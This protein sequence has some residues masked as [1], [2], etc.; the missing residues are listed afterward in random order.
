MTDVNMP[1]EYK[2]VAF[3]NSIINKSLKFK[4][5]P[6]YPKTVSSYPQTVSS[7]SDTVTSICDK[8]VSLPTETVSSDT[9]TVSLE[10]I[11][12]G[13]ETV[14][15]ETETV[16]LPTETVIVKK[17]ILCK[18]CFSLRNDINIKI[19]LNNIPL[20]TLMK[21][22]CVFVYIMDLFD[23]KIMPQL[24]RIVGHNY[25][26]I[27]ANKLDLFPRKCR[28]ER[29]KLII[30]N[31][32]KL[33]NVYV[34]T[35]QIFLIS[36]KSGI[37][38]EPFMAAVSYSARNRGR[39]IH[40]IGISNSGKSSVINRM[41]AS[42]K[43][44]TTSYCP[45]TTLGFIKIKLKSGLNIVDTP[46]LIQT[47]SYTSL[48]TE[49]EL[50]YVVPKKSNFI[51]LNVS[52]TNPY[53]WIDNLIKIS[54]IEGEK[55]IF[56]ICISDKI[57]IYCMNNIDKIIKLNKCIYKYIYKFN[58]NIYEIEGNSWRYPITDI[59]IN[60]I[61]WISIIVKGK[62]K[63]SVDGPIHVN[64]YKRHPILKYIPDN[65]LIKGY[66]NILKRTEILGNMYQR[67]FKE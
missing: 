30:K 51:C 44:I 41:L 21:K 20:I 59:C 3:N 42:Q 9:E 7:Y 66:K 33:N 37:N 58:K 29:L 18:R 63:I 15:S 43:H 45:R 53:T 60:G 40:F 10:S 56:Y 28:Q 49:N 11:S 67:K 1:I 64:I 24:H 16:L 19:P 13:I 55:C 47:G 23:F 5:V 57:P 50:K 65:Q 22:K 38:M 62:I 46:G 52:S 8:T 35:N 48:L 32:L 36:S 26:I 31:T 61:G 17:D 39:D 4:T 12:S 6:S 2:Q 14:S 25:L 54:L 27:A 34:S